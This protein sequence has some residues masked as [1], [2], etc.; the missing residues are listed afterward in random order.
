MKLYCD[1][2]EKSFPLR[3]VKINKKFIKREP[4]VTSELLVASRQKAK[5]LAKK[6]RKLWKASGDIE[7]QQR[8]ARRMANGPANSEL[9]TAQRTVNSEP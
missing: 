8:M 5:L 1:T 3:T 2:F 6:I 4:W 7:K 9:R